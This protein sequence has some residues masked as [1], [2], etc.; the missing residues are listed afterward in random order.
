[1][2]RFWKAFKESWK[3]QSL[4]SKI[5]LFVSLGVLIANL[6]AYSMIKG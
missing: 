2:K 1:M 3:R 5:S 6:V 4:I